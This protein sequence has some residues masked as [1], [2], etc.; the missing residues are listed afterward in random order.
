MSSQ[1]WWVGGRRIVRCLAWLVGVGLTALG[2]TIAG[3]TVVGAQGASERSSPVTLTDTLSY[4]IVDREPDFVRFHI[5]DSSGRNLSGDPAF[6]LQGTF[7][8]AAVRRYVGEVVWPAGADRSEPQ[9]LVVRGGYRQG[10]EDAAGCEPNST[11]R[12]MELCVGFFSADRAPQILDLPNLPGDISRALDIV[13]GKPDL[14]GAID[15]DHIAYSGS[16]LG[17]LAGF[18]LVHPRLA[19]DR[20]RA[21]DL[22]RAI[23]PTW[24]PAFKDPATWAAAPP[25][26]LTVGS[27]DQVITYELVRRTVEAVGGSSTF[28]LVTDVDAGHD[29]SYCR[30]SDRY[31]TRWVRWQV[32]AAKQ[33]GAKIRRSVERSAC[34]EFGLVPGGSTGTGQAGQFIPPNLQP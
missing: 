30:A 13:L 23:A 18:M 17:G 6:P 31:A 7:P 11:V 9:P 4:E 2:V 20:I 16:S 5:I 29:G 19:D 28:S 14:F 24:I 33:P 25:I 3:V 8:P 12:T 21:L 15:T 34:A 27:G 22:R 32:G 10:L 1:G 26:H